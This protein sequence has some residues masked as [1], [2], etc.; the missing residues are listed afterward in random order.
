M[1]QVQMATCLLQIDRHAEA[2]PMLQHVVDM[3]AALP[4]GKLSTTYLM[5]AHFLS[6]SVALPPPSARSH[7]RRVLFHPLI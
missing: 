7:A 2:E 5:A 3:H 4:E 1:P 6:M